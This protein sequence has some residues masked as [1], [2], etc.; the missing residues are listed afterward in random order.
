MLSQPIKWVLVFTAV[1][2]LPIAGSAQTTIKA[3]YFLPARPENVTW[4]WILI[5][6]E[7]VLRIKSGQSVRI[8][9]ISHHGSTQEEHPVK[10]L[11][12]YGVKPEEVLKDVID[13]WETRAGRPAGEGRG[14][15]V[16]TGPIYIEDAQP[17]DML[18]IQVLDVE[19]RVPYGFNGAGPTSGVLGP[20]YPGF[21]EGDPPGAGVRKLYRTAKVG[22]KTVV[23]FGDGITFDAAPFMGNMAVAPPVP[24]PG[25]PVGMPL[26]STRPPG[27]FGGNMDTRDLGAGSKVFLPVFQPG[28][29]FYTG[30]PHSVQGGG[31]V[32]GTAIEHSATAT[33]RFILHKGKTISAPRAETATDYVVMGI[34]VDLDRAMRLA[35]HQAIE[36]LVN[37]MGMTAGDAFSLASLAVR[38]NVEEAVNGTQVISGRIPKHIFSKEFLQKRDVR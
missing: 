10:F 36:F 37:E 32:S 4:G 24:V 28:A 8:D 20:N 34:D 14:G 12:Q 35:V 23:L 29:L 13:F 11:A 3:D 15:H 18:E 33:M 1:L 25:P 16:M 5:D 7:P 21:R 38:F 27:V 17:G 9:A 2:A 6:K 19:L 31:E 22:N 26:Q 30:D